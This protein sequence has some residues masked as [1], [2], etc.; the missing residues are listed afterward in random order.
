MLAIITVLGPMHRTGPYAPYWAWW[1]G[2]TGHGGKAVPGMVGS[3]LPGMVPLPTPLV[4]TIL[5]GTPTLHTMVSISTA[6]LT[7]AHQ[8]DREECLGS[9]KEKGLGRGL[10]LTK[11]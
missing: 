3:T 10:L 8:R 11:S 2:C 5:P 1:E 6:V 7:V 4:Y 9:R